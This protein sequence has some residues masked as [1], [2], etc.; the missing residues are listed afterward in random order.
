MKLSKYLIS[1]AIAASQLLLTGC[2]LLENPD[3]SGE[4]PYIVNTEVAVNFKLALPDSEGAYDD[5][6]P[7]VSGDFIRRFTLHIVQ[8]DGTVVETYTTYA[9]N[10]AGRTEY[11]FSK[12]FRLNPRQYKVIAWCDF[13]R[14]DDRESHLHYNN[15]SLQPVMPQGNYV[16]NNERK[17]CFRGCVNLDLRSY[18]DEMSPSVYAEMELSRPVGRYEIITT[19]LGAFRNRLKEGLI[20]GNTFTARIRYADYRATAYNVLLDVP[21]NFLSY[22]FYNTNLNTDNWSGEQASMRLGFD[23]CLVDPGENGTKIPLEIEI[24]NENGQ[25]VSRTVLSIPVVQGYNTVVSGRFMTGTDDGSVAV[26]PGY[27]GEINVD[28]GKL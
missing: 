19:D 10:I 18:R 15:E 23:Y 20:S 9:E 1:A 11:E 12:K 13:V 14:V 17:D 28:L 7:E 8:P 5:F 16:G 4:D 22:T 2:V 24:L 6:L 27:D 3:G 25:Q 26:D 21:K